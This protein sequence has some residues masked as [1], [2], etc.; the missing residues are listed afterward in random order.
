MVKFQVP[1]S[2]TFQDMNYHPVTD[3]QTDRQKAMH[4][5]TVQYAQVGSKK[6]R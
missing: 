4:E 2:L 1:N 5:P 3:G 6:E